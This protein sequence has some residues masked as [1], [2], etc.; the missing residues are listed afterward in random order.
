MC[1][2]QWE[3]QLNDIHLRSLKFPKKMLREDRSIFRFFS[4]S[5]E[6]K[7]ILFGYEEATTTSK[8]AVILAVSSFPTAACNKPYLSLKPVY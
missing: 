2:N 7:L 8:M 5:R 3:Y 1:T 6:N 4:D